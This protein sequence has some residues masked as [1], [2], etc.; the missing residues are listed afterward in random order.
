MR[1]AIEHGG[2]LIKLA[3]PGSQELNVQGAVQATVFAWEPKTR[4]AHEL[5]VRARIV[6]AGG[7]LGDIPVVRWFSEIGHGDAVDRDPEPAFPIVAGTLMQNYSLP[8]RGMSWRTPARQFRIGFQN[9]SMLTGAPLT[10]TKIKVSVLPVWGAYTG[11]FPYQTLQ[12]PVVAGVQFPFPLTAREFKLTDAF[13]LPLALGVVTVIFI[14]L[15]GAL[16]GPVD[17]SF[18]ADWRPIPHDAVA[19]GAGP[20]SS[21]AAYR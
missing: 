12:G 20:G 2:H 14:G 19:F 8:A 11:V 4:S 1:D 17:G 13:G 7:V 21:Y 9:I 10:R 16:F 3:G 6:D 15:L 18:Y 5:D